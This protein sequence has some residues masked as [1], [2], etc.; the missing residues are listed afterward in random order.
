[1][2]HRRSKNL[3]ADGIELVVGILDGWKEGLTWEALINAVEL[4]TC[5]RYTRQALSGHH[6]ISHAFRHRKEALK[7]RSR[8]EG[9]QPS[10]PE[11]RVL[12][13]RLARR[14]GEIARIRNE[15]HRLIEQFVVWLYN[16]HLHG[17]TAEDL[18]RPL[19]PTDRGQTVAVL[20]KV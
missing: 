11:V 18:N 7:E 13:E 2:R 20:S 1:V 8:E 10:N 17:L 6:R 3:S 19:P 14:E 15:N 12:Q 9:R 16:A 5:S 4:R